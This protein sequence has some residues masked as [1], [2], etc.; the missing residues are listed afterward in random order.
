MH[1]I[2]ISQLTECSEAT[3]ERHVVHVDNP[4]LVRGEGEGGEVG[5]AHRDGGGLVVR[6]RQMTRVVVDVD[7]SVSAILAHVNLRR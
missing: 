3:R 2:S 6:G 5:G 7:E 4:D 1:V